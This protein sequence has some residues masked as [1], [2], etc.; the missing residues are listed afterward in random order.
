[1]IEILIDRLAALI[2][3]RD[4]LEGEP[5]EAINNEIAIVRNEIVDLMEAPTK[6][7]IEAPK[8]VSHID[9]TRTEKAKANSRARRARRHSFNLN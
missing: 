6:K 1:M 4:L 9:S 8:Q 2:K 5:L 7:F 3:A